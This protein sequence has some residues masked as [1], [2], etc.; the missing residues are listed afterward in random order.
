MK[1]VCASSVLF[2]R[3]A[4]STIGDVTV[5]SDG[6]IS[7][8]HVREANALVIRSK[9]VVNRQLLGGTAISFVGTATAG[10]DH[11]D[12]KYC[13]SAGIACVSAPGSNANSV[14]EYVVSALLCLSERYSMT[15]S[16]LTLGVVGVGEVGSRVVQKARAL[17]MTVV[18][19]D[20]PRYEREGGLD[21]LSLD[22]VLKHSDIVTIH[23]PLTESGPHATRHLANHRF[24]AGMKP[25][26]FFIHSSRGEVV[27]EDALLTSLG[28]G[29]LRG[30]VLDVFENEPRCDP[31]VLQAC[32][33]VTPHIAGYSYDGKLKGTL[34]VYEQACHF[35]EIEPCW[36][37][38]KLTP[39]PPPAIE[40]DARGLL[41]EEAIWRV[42]QSHYDIRNDDRSL[43][44]LSDKGESVLA[45]G[46]NRLRAEYA[47]RREAPAITVRLRFAEPTL[48]DSLIGLGF[49]VSI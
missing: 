12:L 6:D 49:N 10:V 31:R 39:K 35:Y 14:A 38:E 4:F 42:F 36:D 33:L 7:R 41:D 11:M 9:T 18:Q 17:G 48:R 25:G 30:A 13:S 32:E 29:A 43:R 1:V 44:A 22:W 26:A 15:L 37:P 16:D 40:L 8:D 20:P 45:A 28:S 24:F 3:E 46:F 5:V 47:I 34:A 23:V 27:D 2:G 21:L 19:N